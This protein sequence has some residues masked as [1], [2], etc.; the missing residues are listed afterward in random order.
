MQ[1][2]ET[3]TESGLLVT[4][5]KETSRPTQGLVVSTGPGKFTSKGDITPTALSAGD[6][7]LY[8]SYFESSIKIPIE[9]DLYLVLTERDCIA[10]W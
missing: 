2:D 5:N 4:T 7:V 8:S 1:G 6:I 3:E 10:K 9:G